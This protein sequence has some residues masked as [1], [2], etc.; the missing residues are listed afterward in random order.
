MDM[1]GTIKTFILG[2]NIQYLSFHMLFVK[3][4]ELIKKWEWY[5]YDKNDKRVNWKFQYMILYMI[6]RRDTGI[7]WWWKTSLKSTHWS[8]D[9]G[10]GGGVGSFNGDPHHA[11][12]VC[13]DFWH[14]GNCYLD[15]PESSLEYW[16]QEREKSQWETVLVRLKPQHKNKQATFTHTHQNRKLPHYFFSWATLIG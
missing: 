14:R 15:G 7:K 3:L 10:W 16:K 4:C 6:K 2:R 5:L 11:M 1:K 9:G 8:E 12:H 13:R